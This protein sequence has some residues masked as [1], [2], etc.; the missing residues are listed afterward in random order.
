M[1]YRRHVETGRIGIHTGTRLYQINK[2]Q[3]DN[4]RYR[5]HDLEIDN[6]SQAD[7]TDFFCI[8]HPSYTDHDRTEN[9]WRNNH[10]D[11]FN[12]SISQWL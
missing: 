6:G 1:R 4:Q 10:L 8:L 5:C 9:Q 12:K 11:Q 2:H 7:F 3:S